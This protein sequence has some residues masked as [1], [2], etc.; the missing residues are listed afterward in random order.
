MVVSTPAIARTGPI[1][2]MYGGP[3]I[4]NR[5]EVPSDMFHLLR[6]AQLIDDLYPFSWSTFQHKLLLIINNTTENNIYILRK[7]I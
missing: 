7:I 1:D 6:F 2:R 4:I 3:E 5:H